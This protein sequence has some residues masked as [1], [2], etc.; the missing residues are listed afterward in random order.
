MTRRFEKGFTSKCIWK[1]YI[2]A[3]HTTRVMKID[4]PEEIL[5]DKED[6]ESYQQSREA[7][8]TINFIQK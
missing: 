4:R 5:T 2:N 8:I 3:V 6:M 7:L 1:S